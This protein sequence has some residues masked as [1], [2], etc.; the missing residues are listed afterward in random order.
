[1]VLLLGL[2]D[3]GVS[4]DPR[5][6]HPRN[7]H[8]SRPFGNSSGEYVVVESWPHQYPAKFDLVYAADDSLHLVYAHIRVSA[9]SDAY[10]RVNT[11]AVLPVKD[12]FMR[13]R[14]QPTP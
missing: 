4:Q 8:N 12:E 6:Y 1:M 5:P 2:E 13:F 11:N 7:P 10:L 9:T 3:Q 14:L